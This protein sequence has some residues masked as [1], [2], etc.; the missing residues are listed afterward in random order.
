MKNFFSF[1]AFIICL[2]SCQKELVDPAGENGTGSGSG[3][4]SNN[5]NGDLLVK[6][7]SITGA[8]TTIINL[9]WDSNK[10]LSQYLSTGRTNGIATNSRTDITRESN[11]NIK[12]MINSPMGAGGS[13]DSTVSYVYYQPGTSKLSYVKDINYAVGFTFSDSALITYNAAG[14]ISVKEIYFENFI[15]GAMMK[16]S[17]SSYTYDA[18]GNLITNTT[19]TADP[20]TGIYAPGFVITNSYDSHLA[21]ASFGDEAFIVRGLSEESVSANHLIKK[22]QTGSALDITLT[23]SQFQFNSYNR[24]TAEVIAFTPVPPGYT[25]KV[26][27][28]YQ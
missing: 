8:D 18:Q 25:L 17:K 3:G 2:S 19:L 6:G 27:Y 11:G 9:K 16:Q 21:P 23:M 26:T 7:V 15:T 5:S 12:K 10:R 22:V 28:Y 24:P 1:L 20:N 13:F 14:K 4:G